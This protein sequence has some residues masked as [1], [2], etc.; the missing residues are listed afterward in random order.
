MNDKPIKVLLIE[1]NPGDARL[2]RETLAEV[3]AARFDL[4]CVGR[5]STGLECLTAGGVDV[6]LLDLGLPDSLG[7]DTFT[8]V[9]TRA[10]KVPIL[11]LTGLD[12]EA[13][14]VKA[15]REGAQDYLVKGQVTGNLLVRTM[16]HAIERKRAEEE[17]R[18]RTAQ[19][20]ALREVGLELTAQL[21]LDTLLRSIVSRAIELLGGT[22]GGLYL[23]RPEQDVLEWAV[24]IGPNLP[25]IGAVLHWGEGLSGRVWMT[26]ESFFV[27][28]YRQW[29]GQAAIYEAYPFRAT[30]GVP[31]RWGREFLG[32]LNVLADPPRTFSS[33]DA[34]LLNLLATQAAIAI[35]NARLY[36]QAR[37][38]IAERKRAE[39]TIR[40][41]AY[42]DPLTG[43]PNRRL[44][45]DRLELEMAHARRNGHKL[46]VMLLDL[47]HFKEV[48]DTLGH[49][50]GDQLL[51]AV[52]ERLRSLLRKSDTVSRLGGDEFILI[53]PEIVR[54]EDAAGVATKILE[55][56]RDPVEF[57]GHE[58]RITTS[59]GIALY[60]DD[61]ED[62]DALMK[63][64]DIAM[65]RVKD[66]GRD[67]YQ[68]YSLA[69][70]A[71][72]SE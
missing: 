30:V 1:D 52:S 50:M 60:P 4:E 62:G 63:S 19:L 6:V 31:I 53:L 25:P 54:W 58:I 23:H 70:K 15:V 41:M 18:R 49:S 20:E 7:F 40:Q 10:P 39:E 24:A 2:I 69:V 38:E 47:D 51:Q 11:L 35:E 55:A 72:A 44:F 36:E 64:A 16:K 3:R 13:L 5:L 17:I 12:D 68:L 29:E 42:H 14:G 43:L 21:D 32:V 59:V 46:G 61:G 71:E 66:Q 33:A 22:S 67:N 27:N 57:D 28:D 8:R 34:E 37:Q 65:Y 26:G 45:H 56:L 9:H 48:N